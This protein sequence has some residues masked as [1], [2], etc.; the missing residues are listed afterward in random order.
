MLF[1]GTKAAFRH[2][3][4]GRRSSHRDGSVDV[5]TMSVAQAGQG[6]LAR[7]TDATSF[8]VGLEREHLLTYILT[9]HRPTHALFNGVAM[10]RSGLSLEALAAEH[11]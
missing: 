7:R 10:K 4:K 2:D 6:A 1:T 3:G 9:T 8:N 5:Q 11:W